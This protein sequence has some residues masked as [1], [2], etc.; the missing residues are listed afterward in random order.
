MM[1]LKANSLSLE[2]EL[3]TNSSRMFT[4]EECDIHGKENRIHEMKL[5]L[6]DISKQLSDQKLNLLLTIYEI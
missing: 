4:C 5:K 1:E 2:D 3:G 6:I